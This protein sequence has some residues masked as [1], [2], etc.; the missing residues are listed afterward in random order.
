MIRKARI[1]SVRPVRGK[2]ALQVE[3]ADGKRYDVDLREHIRQ[4]PVFQPLEGLSLFGT[5]QVGGWGFDVNWG[6]D[7]ELAVVSLH[8]LALEQAGEVMTG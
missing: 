8:R 3:F 1:S 6:D 2:H 4:F 5:A 7:L